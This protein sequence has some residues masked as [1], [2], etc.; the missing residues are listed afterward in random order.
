VHYGTDL[1]ATQELEYELTPAN[2]LDHQGRVL[3]RLAEAAR[4]IVQ[5][6]DLFAA[7]SQLQDDVAADVSSAARDQYRSATHHRPRVCCA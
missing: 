1:M 7:L 6:H 2:I 4:E 5:D 3:H